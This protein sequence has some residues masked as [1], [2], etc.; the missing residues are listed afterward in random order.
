[1]IIIALIPHLFTVSHACL[2]GLRSCR[3]LMGGRLAQ[4]KSCCA[5]CE[6]FLKGEIDKDWEFILKG[7]F[8]G[9]KVINQSCRC[10]YTCKFWSL[11]DVDHKEFIDKK[12][13]AELSVGYISK[14]NADPI[15]VHNVFAVPTSAL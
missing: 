8:F 2:A 14:A 1:M 4:F 5:L 10:N 7:A 13:L 15:C 12:L 3:H 11:L 6:C 9:F